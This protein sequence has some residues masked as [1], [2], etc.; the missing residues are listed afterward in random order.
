MK[1]LTVLIA[2]L[3]VI[4]P[5]YNYSQDSS[6]IIILSDA[7]GPLLDLK[8]IKQYG[9]FD[10]F[11]KDFIS[12]FFYLSPDS[13]YYCKIKFRS[14]N[15]T[16]D[17]TFTLGYASILNIA[18]RI[19]YLE[20]Q[21]NGEFY[22]N[23]SNVKLKFANGITVKNLDLER[24]Q[25]ATHLFISDKLPI[26]K[27]D[28]DYSEIIERDFEIG[29]SAGVFY[30]SANFNGLGKI[31]N[32]LEEYIPQAP[33][34]IPKTNFNLR[35]SPVLRFSSLLIYKN[36]IMGEFEYATSAHS[37]NSQ[38]LDYKA[39]SISIGY[40]FPNLKNPYPYLSLGYI[41]SKITAI[42]N[43]GVIVDS[44]NGRLES[45]TLEGIAQGLKISMGII[46]NLGRNFGINIYGG[47]NLFPKVKVNQQSTYITI[48]NVP[49]VDFNGFELGISIY[50][51]K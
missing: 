1:N 50:F 12:A 41:T 45:I 38:N 7:V 4:A 19:Q 48:P 22:F 16:K 17:S 42:N 32:L 51:R 24:N 11:E 39:T 34:T 6:K 18:T 23:V 13:Q 15:S 26:N 30:N 14:G 10:K 49:K 40:L 5:N 9:I 28:L 46:Y 3:L 20:S 31:F 33:Y 8:E 43:Y 44:S 36:C 37:G 21:K 25:L 47:Y 2:L 27:L 29:L 35:S